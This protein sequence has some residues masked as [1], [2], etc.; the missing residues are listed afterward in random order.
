MKIC[1]QLIPRLNEI[2]FHTY[3]LMLKLQA[4]LKLLTYCITPI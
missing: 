1:L 4:D 2:A 3:P